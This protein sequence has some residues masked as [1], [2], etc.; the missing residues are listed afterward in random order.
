[1]LVDILRG[2]LWISRKWI[3]TVMKAS[4]K[5]KAQ[6]MVDKIQ[7]G[8]FDEN[9]IDNLFMRLRAYSA[10]FRVFRESADFVAH[11]DAR[12]RGLL[13]ESLQAF[14][15]SFKYFLEYG[16]PGA[17]S[18]DVSKPIPIYIK[19]L[20]KYQVDKCKP[21]DLREKFNVTRERLKSR[22]DN[23]FKDDKKN[24][25]TQLQDFKL[26]RD[27]LATLQHLL[28]F[29]GSVPAFTGEDLAKDLIAVLR[30]NKLVFDEATIISQHPKI[31]L[32]VMLLMHQTK[33]ILESG[34]TG[35]CRICGENTRKV[36]GQDTPPEDTGADSGVIQILGT[37]SL[38]RPDGS[39]M[40][41]SYPIFLSGLQIIDYCDA[42]LFSNGVFPEVSER[43]VPLVDFHGDL[44][45]LEN[46][47]LGRASSSSI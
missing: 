41:V 11:N 31:I 40:K 17:R 2:R 18:L 44:V 22:I 21:E 16:M 4:E 12:D 45:L 5:I 13:N 8:I 29:I 34:A 27:G 23:L 38:V 20:M 26:G 3:G 15:L 24:K 14:H 33:F 6:K 30:H 1:M 46:G 25:T 47:K 42:S 10:G 28:G 36:D 19:K 37:V 39:P 35:E 7:S 9:D 43:R 32:C